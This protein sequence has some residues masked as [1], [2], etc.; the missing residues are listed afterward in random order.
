VKVYDITVTEFGLDR[1]SGSVQS[2]LGWAVWLN[3]H[4]L[5]LSRNQ[6][7]LIGNASDAI[8]ANAKL[9]QAR[10]DRGEWNEREV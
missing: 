3:N 8:L 9:L 4:K 2:L 7:E 5:T 6:A 10:L 1:I